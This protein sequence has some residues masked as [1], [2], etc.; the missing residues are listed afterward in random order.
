MRNSASPPLLDDAF[1]F[2]PRRCL[3]E[4]MSDIFLSSAGEDAL[5]HSNTEQ[6][7]RGKPAG[8]IPVSCRGD[9]DEQRF[10][11]GQHVLTPGTPS[12]FAGCRPSYQTFHGGFWYE[13]RDCSG[14]RER[15]P[16]VTSTLYHSVVGGLGHVPTRASGDDVGQLATAK[17]GQ[18]AHV[19][20][21]TSPLIVLASRASGVD[22]FTQDVLQFIVA[23]LMV[24]NPAPDGRRF[25][26]PHGS[27]ERRSTGWGGQRLILDVR[28]RRTF[29]AMR[30]PDVRFSTWHHPARHASH[31]A[32]VASLTGDDTIGWISSNSAREVRVNTWARGIAFGTPP[33]AAGVEISTRTPAAESSVHSLP[34]SSP[35]PKGA[36]TGSDRAIV[37][38]GTIL[39]SL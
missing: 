11:I 15:W 16:A 32:Q 33:V 1:F 23:R 36:N 2:L 25:A 20:R 26:R 39:F 27:P 6:H 19:A 3:A 35:E 5:A 12:L 31:R 18:G 17:Q 7:N 13:C 4:S 38:R 9:L 14:R 21:D 37:A 29:C 8:D 10:A 22:G 30:H 34:S 24:G 28:A